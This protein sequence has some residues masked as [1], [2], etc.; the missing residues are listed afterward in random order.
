MSKRLKPAGKVVKAVGLKGDVKVFPIDSYIN[1]IPNQ[2]FFFIGDTAEKAKKHYISFVTKSGKFLRY[3]IHEN[4]DRKDAEN[5]VGKLIFRT[6]PDD[7]LLNEDL[8]GFLVVTTDG[9]P[10]GILSDILTFPGQDVYSIDSGEKEILIPS[11]PEIIK[12]IDIKSETI[13]IFPMEGLLD[14]W[15]K[16]S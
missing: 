13:S 8:I 11:V 7:E 12:E 9:L 6:V 4:V 2:E 5:L 14:L 1:H 16:F 10:I 3:K 15:C